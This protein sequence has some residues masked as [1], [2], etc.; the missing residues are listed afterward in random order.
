MAQPFVGAVV[1]EPFVEEILQLR[2]GETRFAFGVA[3]AADDV[4]AV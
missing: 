3:A 1:D 4:G 2:D